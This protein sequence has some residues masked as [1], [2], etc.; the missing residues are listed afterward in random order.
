MAHYGSIGSQAVSKEV[1]DVRGTKLSAAEGTRL[2][3]VSDVIFDHDTMKIRYVVVDGEGKLKAT[4][5]LL[6]ADRI[7]AD[8]KDE[9]RLVAAMTTRQIERS[10]QY[11]K[12]LLGSE[13]DWKKYDQNFKKYW[14]E[15][16]VM[17]R[18]DTYRI[19]T[20]AEPVRP[21]TTPSRQ[22]K[23]SQTNAAGSLDPA[24]LYP[25][26]ISKVFSDAAP[27]G[28]KVTLRPKPAARI[29]EAAAGVTLL[30]PRWWEDFENYLR[31]NKESFHAQCTLCMSKTA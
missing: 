10:P 23:E 6:P 2:G 31:T 11:N 21:Q 17:Y 18:K 30:K 4:T 16:P 26:R 25:E 15:E 1:H 13:N 9:N 22:T 27:S 28:G 14:A 3:K 5:F 8:E 7:F 29:E 12:G 20:P 24:T 19:V